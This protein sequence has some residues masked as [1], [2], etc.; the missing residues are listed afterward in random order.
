[1][2]LGP[3]DVLVQVKAAS[4]NFPDILMTAGQYQAKPPLPFVPGMEVSGIVLDVGPATTA[5]TSSKLRKGDKVMCL[6]GTGGFATRVVVREAQC[7][8]LPSTWSFEEG[9]ASLVAYTTAYHGLVERAN[10]Q[11]GETVLVG[12][13]A[14]QI[15]KLLGATV[16][17]TGSTDAKLDIVRRHAGADHVINYVRTPQF[18]DEVKRLSN[19][20]GG[21]DVVYDPVGGDTTLESIRSTTYGARIVLIGHAGGKHAQLPATL[22]L[23]KGLS[24]MGARAGEYVRRFPE[25]NAARMERILGWAESGRLRMHISHRL[26]LARIV[27]AM[28][29]LWDRQVVGKAVVTMDDEDNAHAPAHGRPRL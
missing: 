6:M 28:Q 7:Q 12:F 13:A 18:R 29:L 11:P 17:A 26:P 24:I 27:D 16:I 4:V 15:A 20:G 8:R 25:H 5:S 22:I 10:V 23:I 2:S 9:A 1:M 14:V 3:G 21:V 19:G